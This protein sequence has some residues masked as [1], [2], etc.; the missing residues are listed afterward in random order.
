[1]ESTMFRRAIVRPPGENFAE[2]LTST[3]QGLPGFALAV[4]QHET[5]CA[6]LESC[7]LE[8]LRLPPD[9]E[10]PDSTFVE[11]TAVLTN[12]SAI[13]ARPG[14]RSRLGEVAG[15]RD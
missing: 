12:G 13:L 9:L 4:A 8:L 14:A 7:G 15:V 5:Y 11:D 10:H 6:A 1:M 3:N 2:G